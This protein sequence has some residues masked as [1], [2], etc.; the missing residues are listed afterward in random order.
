MLNDNHKVV[1][2]DPFHNITP[3]QRLCILKA[4]RPG[5]LPGAIADFVA[6]ELGEKFTQ[7][8]AFSLNLSYQASNCKQPLLF[9]LPGTDPM[10]ALMN[11]A[12]SKGVTLRSVSL[13]QGQG[14][15]AERE[16][17]DAKQLGN[18]VIL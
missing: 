15:I 9:L 13:G 10:N 11:F 2:P 6:S 5:K 4:M 16:I 3:M 8:P 12:D 7:P 18:W 17:D 1:L 14:V